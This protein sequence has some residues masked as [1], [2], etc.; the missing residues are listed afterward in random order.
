VELLA[1]I[2]H[3][4]LIILDHYT[5]IFP[6]LFV[7]NTPDNRLAKILIFLIFL[8]ISQAGGIGY[9]NEQNFFL[10]FLKSVILR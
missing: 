10:E 9:K 6:Y 5:S 2:L 8:I 3:I 1:Q 4:I 7:G